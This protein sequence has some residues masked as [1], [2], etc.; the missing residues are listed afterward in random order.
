MTRLATAFL[1]FVLFPTSLFSTTA[2]DLRA[3]I[4]IDGRAVEYEADEWVL[5]ASTSL[6]E[7]PNDSRWGSDNDI[8]EVA[9]TWDNYNLYIA[10]RATTRRT[11]L[12]LFIDSACDGATDLKDHPV[13]RRNIRFGSASPNF[14]LD[15]TPFAAVTAGFQDCSKPFFVYDPSRLQQERAEA[16]EVAIPWTLLGSFDISGTGTATPEANFI[17]DVVAAV[18]GGPGAGAG[19]AAPDPSTILEDDSTRVAIL[20][21]AMQLPLD[22]NGDGLIDLGVSPRSVVSFALAA[23]ETARS[24]LPLEVMLERKLFTP[25]TGEV[26][27]F[28]ASLQPPDYGLTVYLSANV[29][30]SNGRLLR[31]LYED[32]PRDLSAGAPPVWDEWD[33]RDNHGRTVPGG[34]YILALSGSPAER[35]S[36]KTV[37]ASVAVVR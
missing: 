9:L 13:F 31:N 29:Y 2:P 5:D 37:K 24:V 16:L 34:I 7:R 1:L 4:N 8:G 32:E 12:M 11:H 36:T 3:R 33:G 30:S 21:N 14:L 27:R 19:D 23:T 6:P 22:G 10:V 35:S 26:L 20:D 28:R 25:D 15:V 18:T 17:V